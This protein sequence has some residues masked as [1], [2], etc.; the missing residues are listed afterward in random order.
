MTRQGGCGCCGNWRK[1]FSSRGTSKMCPCIGYQDPGYLSIFMPTPD[2]MYA[3]EPQAENVEQSFWTG[4]LPSAQHT[5]CQERPASD[6]SRQAA[7]ASSTT[8]CWAVTGEIRVTSVTC[9]AMPD[10]LRVAGTVSGG[11]KR[12]TRP[13]SAHGS[14][15]SSVANLFF[16]RCQD[17]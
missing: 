7:H 10:C 5:N 12:D 1:G 9:T 17:A 8:P 15:P 2:P 6:F 13:C 16:C 4:T 3:N 14:D 11:F